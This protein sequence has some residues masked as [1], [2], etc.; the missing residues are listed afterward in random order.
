[1]KKILLI[2]VVIYT[3]WAVAASDAAHS[4]SELHFEHPPT[5]IATLDW[6]LSETVM[7][8]G[9]T[10]VAASD[11]KNYNQWVSKPALPDKV[12]DLG[13]RTEPNTEL[14]AKL[15]PD[16]ILISSYLLPAYETLSSIAPVAVV[17]IYKDNQTP[18]ANA[19]KL[20]RDLGQLLGREQQAEALIEQTVQHLKDNGAKLQQ[21][22]L[23]Q[24]N[25][26]FIRFVNQQTLR[27]HGKGSL[28]NDTITR[29][30]LHNEWQ[31][32]TNS[33]G[34]STTEISKIAEHQDS[35]VMIFG[36]LRPKDK[37]SLTQ[38]PLWQAMA[39][40]RNKQV[41]ELPAIWSF[42]SL[43]AARRLSDNVTR[44]L[45]KNHE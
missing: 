11:T 40:T 4:L 36:P 28:I 19:E 41:Y 44:L 7:S 22:G 30:G 45:T 18:F 31:Q 15:K 32:N 16:L 24:G 21:A 13:S 35:R 1:M 38:S 9:V 20:T 23:G 14:L 39:F 10:P 34:F 12:A 2:L 3:N 5:R 43:I 33:W 42:G 29:M 6:A 37:Q 26:M 8:L 25:L 17:D 27:I